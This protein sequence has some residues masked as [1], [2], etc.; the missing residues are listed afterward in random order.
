MV[1]KGN[2]KALELAL[3]GAPSVIIIVSLVANL[4]S[5]TAIAPLLLGIIVQIRYLT[6]IKNSC[7]TR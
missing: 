5:A 2:L 3:V 4:L 7:I 6:Y 1:S